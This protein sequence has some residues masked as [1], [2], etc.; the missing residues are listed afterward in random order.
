[1]FQF[2]LP[3][4]S[5]YSIGFGSIVTTN[6]LLDIQSALHQTKRRF[7]DFVFQCV[8]L[9][10]KDKENGS[11]GPDDSSP[12]PNPAAQ[13]LLRSPRSVGSLHVP[14]RRKAQA[15]SSTG[16]PLVR[17]T[18]PGAE[19][20]EAQRA[21]AA[22]K[23]AEEKR[24]RALYSSPAPQPVS[25]RP[26]S[27]GT[28]S[29]TGS[30][31]RSS[32]PSS[33]HVHPVRRFQISRP[34]ISSHRPSHSFGG[35]QKHRGY[36]AAPGVAV[37]VEQLRRNPHSRQASRVADMVER[38]QAQGKDDAI[39]IPE[40]APK[41]PPRKRP[42]VNKAERE[43]RQ[44][45]QGAI[46]TAK[47]NLSNML[48]KSAQEKQ[49]TWDEESE[50][51]A[52]E[53]EQVAL[54]LEHGM[55]LDGPGTG[56]GAPSKPSYKPGS[57]PRPP[58]KFQPRPPKKPRAVP[59]QP[60]AG[61]K[62]MSDAAVPEEESEDDYVYD[63]YIRRPLGENDMLKNPLAEYESEQQ[64]KH[65]AD[66]GVGV[67]VITA[68]D[69]EYWEHF[70]ED[71]EEAWDSEDAESN[72]A[73]S[74]FF[75]FPPL[76]PLRHPPRNP[77]NLI[78]DFI[79]QPRIIPPMNTQTKNFPPMTK[80]TTPPPFTASTEIGRGG[81]KTN[82]TLTI[83]TA[84]AAPGLGLADATASTGTRT[85]TASDSI[86]RA[87]RGPF[88]LGMGVADV[89]EWHV[90][91][92]MRIRGLAVRKKQISSNLRLVWQQTVSRERRSEEF[93]WSRPLQA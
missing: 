49:S 26:S 66:A 76:I 31:G 60:P 87:I 10:G 18:S 25:E 48:E 73:S 65:A 91:C 88:G 64:K 1:M 82:L 85:T 86:A 54:E 67:I 34:S 51:L 17:A 21:A 57:I 20:R 7:T 3:L 22:Q 59:S 33:S 78:T 12:A 61:D 42:V 32:R 58:S 35:I 29:E 62:E 52:R 16:V 28:S 27:A 39:N 55:D 72:G 15:T 93:H 37:L 89:T 71:D 11:D 63:V 43:W 4:D 13:R 74:S 79:P 46:S 8:T 45:R 40:T 44:A 83:P 24:R 6:N 23:E 90:A 77:E 92:C 75:V 56:N 2:I 5:S 68:E 69:E 19:I 84:T 81:T 30:R 9:S 70:V 80:T 50:R 47:Q 36:G 53:F 14:N 41:S 38:A